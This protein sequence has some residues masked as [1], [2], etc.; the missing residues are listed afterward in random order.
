MILIKWNSVKNT[1]AY[2]LAIIH[3]VHQESISLLILVKALY[4]LRNI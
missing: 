1:E 3:G 4:A 2:T